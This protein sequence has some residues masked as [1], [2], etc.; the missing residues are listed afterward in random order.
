MIT[1]AVAKDKYIG[2]EVDDPLVKKILEFLQ[3]IDAES[4]NKLSEVAIISADYIVAYTNT[5]RSVQIRIGKLERLDEKARLTEDFLKDLETN[6]NPIEYVDFNYTA[7][8][9]KLAR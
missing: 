8:F 3:K 2:D 6:P 4:L 5:E 7:P 1:G 9:I